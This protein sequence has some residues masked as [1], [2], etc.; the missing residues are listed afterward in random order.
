MKNPLHGMA[1]KIGRFRFNTEDGRQ[2]ALSE[3][4]GSGDGQTGGL[5]LMTV[6]IVVLALHLVVIGGISAWHFVKGPSE[7]AVDASKEAVASD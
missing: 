6:F 7:A 3:N 4:E 5:K 2:A 1:A